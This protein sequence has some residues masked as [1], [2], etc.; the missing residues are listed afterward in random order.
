MSF[1]MKR[2]L[3]ALFC[4]TASI[5]FCADNLIANPNGE[6]EFKGFWKSPRAGITSENGVIV[7][8][9]IPESQK[10]SENFTKLMQVIKRPQE[11]LQNK[12]M[13]LSFQ[14]RLAKI[15]GSL[16]I[17]VREAFGK[18][19]LYHGRIFK[20]YDGGRE[21]RKIS[22]PFTTRAN[23]SAL[24]FYLSAGYLAPDDRIEIKDLQLSEQ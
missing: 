4:L 13:I 20:H 19:A 12:K 17:A 21:W 1:I 11:E 23:T 3:T 2:I 7:L 15:S 18:K 22:V 6:N 9:G 8:S 16:Q 5:C 10:D 14:I 24:M